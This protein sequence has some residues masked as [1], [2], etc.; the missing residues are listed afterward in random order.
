MEERV[1]E[2]TAELYETNLQLQREVAERKR[3]EEEIR[4]LNEELEQRLIQ[5]TSQ[6]EAANQDLES[7]SFSVSHDLRAPLR[8]IMGFTSI[9]H[10]DFAEEISPEAKE[11]LMR[12]NSSAHQMNQLILDLLTFSRLGRRE[13]NKFSVNCTEL[14]RTAYEEL[15]VE[16]PDRDIEIEIAEMPECMA[17]PALLKQVYVN[18]ISNALKFTR[19]RETARIQIY[20][21]AGV[22]IIIDNGVGFDTSNKD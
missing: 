22:F 13:I 6:L 16:E 2:R 3:A 12:I 9:L 11:H 19:L 5:R 21:E 17:D 4:K 14:A 8:A 20:A 18:L 1:N 15:T 7:F 10:E